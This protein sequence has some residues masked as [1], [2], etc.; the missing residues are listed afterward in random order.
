MKAQEA[1]RSEKVLLHCIRTLGVSPINILPNLACYSNILKRLRS[2]DEIR[3]I[4][5]LQI[6]VV[7]QFVLKRHRL[8]DLGACGCVGNIEVEDGRVKEVVIARA[9]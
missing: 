6:L 9:A 7:K 4:P 1:V 5:F 2:A 3:V 8:H